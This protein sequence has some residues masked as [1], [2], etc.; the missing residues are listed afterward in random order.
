MR[1]WKVRLA[2]AAIACTATWVLPQAAI[3][4]ELVV[5]ATGG[6]F[7]DALKK[8]FY[9]PFTAATG[10]EIVT[11]PAAVAEQNAKLRAMRKAGQVEYDVLTTTAMAVIAD[12][13][14]YAD[15]DC[16][17]IPNA[18]AFGVA[19]TCGAKS[20][21]RT[22]GAIMI[23]YKESAF[24]NGGPQS[25][26]EFW[27]V[28][29]F[30]GARCLP[31]GSLENHMPFLAAL[32]ADGA[33]PAD[34]Y[35]IDFDRALE[36][37]AELKPH[38]AAYWT[39]YSQSQ[40]FLRD[41]ECV[42]SMMLNGRALSLRKEGFPL[43]IVWNEALTYSAGWG[44]AEGAPNADAAYKF[45]DFWMKDPKAHLAFYQTFFY[46]TAHKDVVGLMDEADLA[47]YYAK[48]DNLVGQVPIDAAW[49]GNHRDEISRTYANFLAQ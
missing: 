13:D 16:A 4:D 6:G 41:G 29:A 9:D 26:A 47:L 34:L 48:P 40:Q 3:S 22:V 37:L 20:L 19:G 5:V 30:P 18:Q 33:A 46:A 44:I 10:I 11:V 23:A 31:G 39:S 8:H 25:W 35:P 21:L 28:E 7:G 14:V 32:L 2:A 43:K 15:L 1:T 17:R 42:L 36:K 45:L 27:D 12:D 49:I 24:P 38:V